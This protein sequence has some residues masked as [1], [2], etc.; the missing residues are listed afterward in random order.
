MPATGASDT[1]R[2]RQPSI[3]AVMLALALAACGSPASSGVWSE[4]GRRARARHAWHC[5]D[6]STRPPGAVVRQTVRARPSPPDARCDFARYLCREI[7]RGAQANEVERDACR[8]YER[9]HGRVTD[10]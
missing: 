10:P 8:Q 4:A 3:A 6:Q 5:S 1:D 7:H 2:V 9:V